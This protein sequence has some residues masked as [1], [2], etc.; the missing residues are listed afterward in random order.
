[1]HDGAE[2]LD[3]ASRIL[4]FISASQDMPAEH[5]NSING[6]FELLSHSFVDSVEPSLMLFGLAGKNLW[7]RGELG[8]LLGSISVG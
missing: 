7:Q 4:I 5:R 8:V 3:D 1:M 6:V 2:A